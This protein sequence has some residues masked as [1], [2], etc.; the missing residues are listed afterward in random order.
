M[1]KKTI[2]FRPLAGIN[3]NSKLY[4]QTTKIFRKKQ[5][6]AHYTCIIPRFSRKEKNFFEKSCFSVVRTHDFPTDR[7]KQIVFK[8]GY[9]NYGKYE[10]NDIGMNVNEYLSH[11]GLLIS[12]MKTGLGRDDLFRWRIHPLCFLR[13]RLL[14]PVNEAVCMRKHLYPSTK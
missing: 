5:K 12:G 11:D 7:E 9:W 2:S 1:K 4:W 10:Y 6:A 13:Q 3:C 8:T 14:Y